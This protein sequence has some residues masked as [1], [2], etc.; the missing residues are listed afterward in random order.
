M[1][2]KEKRALLESIKRLPPEKQTY[3]A[4]VAAGLA[5]SEPLKLDQ[6]EAEKPEQGKPDSKHENEGP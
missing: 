3:V 6:A 4:G 5:M 1:S 2:D